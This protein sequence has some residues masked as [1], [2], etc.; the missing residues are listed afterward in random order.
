MGAGMA[1][2]TEQPVRSFLY[3]DLLGHISSLLSWHFEPQKAVEH[4]VDE[5]ISKLAIQACWVQFYDA[6]QKELRLITCQGFPEEITAKMNLMKIGKDPVSEVIL[7]EKPWICSDITTDLHHGFIISGMPGIRSL[8]VIPLLWNE[9]VLGVMGFCSSAPNRFVEYEFKLLSIV[10]VFIALLINKMITLQDKNRTTTAQVIELGE[11]QEL[12]NTLSHELQTPLTA[13][14]ASAGMLAEEI[15]K[16]PKGSQPRL[17]ENIVHSA[18]SLQNRLIELLDISRTKANQFRVKMKLINFSNL[19][20]EVIQELTPV[21]ESK[22][23]SL[24]TEVPPSINVEADEQRL[25]QILNNLL[26]NAIKFSPQGGEIK[27]KVEKHDFDFLVAIKDTGPGIS[28]EEQQ[29]L[30]RPY[31]RVPADRRRY[32]GLGLGLFITKQL[33]EL[34]GGKIWIDSEVE[35]GSTFV[36]SLPLS[37]RNQ[38]NSS[39]RTMV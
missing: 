1:K 11:K 13:I 9:T 3:L 10:A 27:V 8:A 37:K 31:Y 29:K 25:E 32:N 17:I 14:I 36:F 19:L 23:Q 15:E 22:N 2:S 30:F 5:L 24:V 21:A 16:E 34:H 7:K 18:M 33:V 39:K 4:V 38:N 28:K 12:I 20:L 35:H 26:S 6:S